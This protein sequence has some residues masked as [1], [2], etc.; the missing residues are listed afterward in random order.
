MRGRILLAGESWISGATHVKGFDSF[1]SASYHTGADPLIGVLRGAGF[2]VSFQPSHQAATDFPLSLE[3][4][5]AFDAV[6]LSDIGANTLLLHPDTWFQGKAMPNR[7]KLL[8][9][10]VEAG[11]GLAMAGG[12]LS[13][14]G[15][16]A[17][18]HYHRTPVERV[19]PVLISPYDDRLEVPQGAH[20]QPTGLAHPILEGLTGPWPALL[21]YNVLEARP[22]SSVLLRVGDDPL[23]AVRQ[24]GGGRTLVWASDIGPHWCPQTFV[25]WPGYSRLFVQAMGW[26]C[27][28]QR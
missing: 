2:E 21:G 6:L 25:D 11:G 17:A 23:L 19:L 28:E 24:V 9:Q 22:D 18:A 8:E 27:G 10:Y 1:Y 7:L 13:F 15:I 26:L 5:R 20:P 3:A 4:L 12:Y 16:N 14:A